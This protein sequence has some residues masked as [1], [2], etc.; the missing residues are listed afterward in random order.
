L[1][2]DIVTSLSRAIPSLIERFH[3]FRSY[4]SMLSNLHDSCSKNNKQASAL[5]A[6][7]SSGYYCFPSGI[8]VAYPAQQ[9]FAQGVIVS[10]RT[11]G[12]GYDN[13]YRGQRALSSS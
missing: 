3:L 5:T 9:K 4:P 7:A 11:G 12:N 2:L 13:S 1:L 8:P 6:C 10:K